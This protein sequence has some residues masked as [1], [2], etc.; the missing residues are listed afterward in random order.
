MKSLEH[1]A[2]QNRSGHDWHLD[3]GANV[4]CHVVTIHILF[5]LY[6]A[7]VEGEKMFISRVTRDHG[8]CLQR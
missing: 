7:E 8:L 4:L 1:M 6:G 2:R 5:I 3:G